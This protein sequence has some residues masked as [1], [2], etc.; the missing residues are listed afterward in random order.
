MTFRRSKRSATCPAGN[1]KKSPGK[2]NANPVY[3]RSSGRWVIEYTC[4]ATATDCASA[5]RITATRASWYRLKSRKAKASKPRRGGFGEGESIYGLGYTVAPPHRPDLH[6]ASGA[7]L[8]GPAPMTM[9]YPDDWTPASNLANIP[10]P[11]HGQRSPSPSAA[12]AP[13]LRFIARSRSFLC[14]PV[15]SMLPKPASA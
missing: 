7:F 4:H 3:P 6:C 14:S 2:N 9:H 1:R 8:A 5:P 15:Y 12:S 10:C 13:F 11:A